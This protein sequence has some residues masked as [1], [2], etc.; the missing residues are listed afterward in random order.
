MCL[1]VS[2]FIHNTDYS[3]KSASLTGLIHK[4]VKWDRGHGFDEEFALDFANLKKAVAE[5]VEVALLDMEAHSDH[6]C[7]VL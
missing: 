3:S 1:F 5:A 2:P 4:D 6:P 7:E